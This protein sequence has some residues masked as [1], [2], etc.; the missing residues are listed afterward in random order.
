MQEAV[1]ARV[2]ALVG[3]ELEDTY[4][5]QVEAAMRAGREDPVMD[6]YNGYD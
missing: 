2:Q 1:F 3:E 4:P 6:E 5:S